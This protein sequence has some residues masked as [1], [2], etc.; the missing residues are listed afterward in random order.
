MMIISLIRVTSTL[1]GILDVFV[2]LF[3]ISSVYTI[4]HHY[5][6]SKKEQ[7]EAEATYALPK[8]DKSPQKEK[9]WQEIIIGRWSV[10]DADNMDEWTA[11]NK[12][13]TVKKMLFNTFFFKIKQTVEISE[14]YFQFSRYLKNPDDPSIVAKMKIYSS[15]EEAEEHRDDCQVLDPSDNVIKR[16]ATY[17]NEEEKTFSTIIVP[18]DTSGTKLHLTHVRKVIDEDTLSMVCS[19]VY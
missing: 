7:A 16:F 6:S 17:I 9:T 2:P 12:L 8:V 5:K 4:Y 15:E 18:T 3:F 11:F 10:S 14:G 19:D 1:N 13:S